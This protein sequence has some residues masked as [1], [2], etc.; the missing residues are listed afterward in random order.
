MKLKYIYIYKLYSSEKG[1]CL[2]CIVYLDM[3][4]IS[5]TLPR[6]KD[7]TLLFK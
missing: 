4:N 3:P 7:W 6:F 1:N 5:H 2:K